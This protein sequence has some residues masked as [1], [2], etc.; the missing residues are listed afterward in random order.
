MAFPLAPDPYSGNRPAAPTLS[1]EEAQSVV[2]TKTAPR[3]TKESIE[4]KIQ[5]VQYI[6]DG[7]LTICI[8][9]MQSGFRQVG[10]AAPADPANY[11]VQVGERYA[12]EDAFKPLWKLEGYLLCETLSKAGLG[13]E[14]P[15]T[16]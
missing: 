16:R 10:V 4:A 1:F 12:F 3:V 6:H 14:P 5:H 2:A 7:A 13:A 11:D 9:T 8:L 15:P